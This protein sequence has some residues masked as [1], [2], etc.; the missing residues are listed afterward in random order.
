MDNNYLPLYRRIYR[1]YLDQYSSFRFT[2]KI[3]L[4]LRWNGY[5]FILKYYYFLKLNIG[6]K[7]YI[8]SSLSHYLNQHKC[9]ILS[10]E[11]KNYFFVD[12]PKFSNNIYFKE[13]DLSSI[14]VVS[15]GVEIFFIKQAKVMA[16]TN[17]IFKD[18]FAIHPDEYIPEIE[19][20]PAET[21]KV[22]VVNDAFTSINFSSIN[23]VIVVK[24]L[25]ASLLG[26][27]AGNYAHWLTE[28]LPKLAVLDTLEEYTNI[29]LIV[30][31]W[32]HPNFYESIDLLCNKRRPLIKI[33]RW[34]KVLVENLL[35][36]STTSYI[37]AESRKSLE[38]KKFIN[39]DAMKFSFSKFSIKLMR[40]KIIEKIP[41]L[42]IK[43]EKIFI[44]RES[45]FNSR[46]AINADE[47]ERIAIDLG[48][49]IVE[50]GRMSFSEQVALFRSAKVIA[51]QIGAALTNAI[52]SEQSTLIILSPYY[53]N[54][55]YNF[56]SSLM[57]M[58]GHNVTYVIGPQVEDNNHL[59]HRNYMIDP[60]DFK[61]AL[62]K[63]HYK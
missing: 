32:V 12:A 49:T 8:F 38:S 63:V 30:D 15:P 10:I 43:I 33:G 59:L 48:Y 36:I 45:T 55:N 34:E 11:K 52:F 26:Q 23:K 17:F 1:K 9:E 39:D 44:R 28:V 13:N 47:L 22:A 27:C 5:S 19:V 62:E 14:K 4:A 61:S 21:A 3:I 16:G 18:D 35:G 20:C 56:F 37:P 60:L 42:E 40:E 51:G 46:N 41:P 6:S 2:K 29:P 54:A 57:G 24:E 7:R 31:G 58:L 25:S 53:E 50:P